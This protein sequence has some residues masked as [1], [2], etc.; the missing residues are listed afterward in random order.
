MAEHKR[1]FVELN[2]DASDLIGMTTDEVISLER[3]R[4]LNVQAG[5]R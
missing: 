2:L 1:G 3:Q 4:K 5:Y